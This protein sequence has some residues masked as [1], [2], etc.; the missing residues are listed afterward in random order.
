MPKRRGVGGIALHADGGFVCS[1]RDSCTFA[2]ARRVTVFTIEGLPG[3][4]DLCTD[5]RAGVYAGALRFAVF[6]RDRQPRARRAAGGS[7]ARPE[8]H[9]LYGD[10]VHA[11]GIALSP[12]GQH[13]LPLGHAASA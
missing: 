9:A 4:N 8:R 13:D 5:A 12:D 2:T 11:N 6:D 1:G 10:V 7:T 3:W